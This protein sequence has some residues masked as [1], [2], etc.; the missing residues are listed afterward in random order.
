MTDYQFFFI[1]LRTMWM[2]TFYCLHEIYSALISSVIRFYSVF[3][4]ILT[5]PQT[6]S[7][8]IWPH[9]KTVKLSLKTRLFDVLSFECGR[10]STCLLL[11]LLLIVFKFGLFLQRPPL[12]V[13]KCD[14][15]G[16]I[17]RVKAW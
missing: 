10:L 11:Q 5:F 7:F 1:A 14:S 3:E 2:S 9:F 13:P 8:P 16:P 4:V 17:Y 6:F 15:K 12:Q